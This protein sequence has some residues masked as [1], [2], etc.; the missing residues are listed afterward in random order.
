MN[1]LS[2]I[3]LSLEIAYC[4]TILFNHHIIRLVRFVSEI[5]LK[6]VE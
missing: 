3:N 4:S 6:V 2:I 5:K 1:L